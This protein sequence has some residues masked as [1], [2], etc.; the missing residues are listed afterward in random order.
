LTPSHNRAAIYAQHKFR[1]EFDDAVAFIDR[2]L[3]LNPNLARAW[4][5][6]GWLR[7]WRGEPDLALEH[8]AHAMR[9]SPLDPSKYGMHGAMAYAHFLASRYDMASSCAEKAMR[10]NP[11]FLLAICIS[12]ASNALAGRLEPAQRA[13]ARALE[14]DPDLHASNLRDLAP[15]RRAEDFATFANCLRKAGLPE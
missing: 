5:L 9:L 12:A 4:T 10:D 3:A 7:V 13:M 15:F 6:S 2:G 14:C 1:Q 8:V 11:T